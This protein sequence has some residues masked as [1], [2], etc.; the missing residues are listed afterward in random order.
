[1]YCL[2]SN[3]RTIFWSENLFFFFLGTRCLILC[4]HL[5]LVLKCKSV[6]LLAKRDR[7]RSRVSC[8]KERRIPIVAGGMGVGVVR[9]TA[10]AREMCA[11]SQQ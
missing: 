6:K 3:A 8:A 9:V 11:L 10:R 4:L 1:M 5:S 7:R 2:S